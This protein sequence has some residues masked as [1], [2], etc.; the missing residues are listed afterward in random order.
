MLLIVLEYHLYCRIWCI[1]LT[2]F[3]KSCERV[4]G[5]A[6]CSWEYK[7]QELL[8]DTKLN[9]SQQS[10]F[11]TKVANSFLGCIRQSVRCREVILPP[12]HERHGHTDWVQWGA[13]KVIKG[14][15]HVS[16][17][18]RLGETGP[19]SLKRRRVGPYFCLQALTGKVYSRLP[20]SPQIR[21]QTA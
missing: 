18:E 2:P 8:V 5:K 17:E 16:D 3:L 21:I 15:E 6:S 14:L 1:K 13:A 19:F 12:V 9:M 20:D 10:T 11:A 7:D 4:S